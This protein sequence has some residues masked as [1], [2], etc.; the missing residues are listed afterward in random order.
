MNIKVR[1]TIEAT[2][3]ENYVSLVQMDREVI[4]LNHADEDETFACRL[5]AL[6]LYDDDPE[7]GA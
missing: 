2:I 3:P 4:L 6:E 5:L 7:R 1:L